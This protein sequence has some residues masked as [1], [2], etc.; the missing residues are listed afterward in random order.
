MKHAAKPLH[1]VP[2]ILAGNA[3][4]ARKLMKSVECCA[5][6]AQIDVMDGTFVPNKTITPAAL[7]HLKTPLK[8]EYHLMV[9]KPLPFVDKAWKSGAWSAIFHLEACKRP[10]DVRTVIRHIKRRKMKAGLAINPE[11]PANA[12][13]PYLHLLDIVLVMT[14]HPGAAG[15]SFV[16]HTLDKIRQIRKWNKKIDIEVDGGI[17]QYTVPKAVKAGANRLVVGSALYTARDGPVLMLSKLKH[18]AE[19]HR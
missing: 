10:L 14:V 5:A 17:N 3:R 4:A 2:A 6:Y 13:K 16:T 1:I 8:L 11:T 19:K 9:A 15:Q 12:V 18:L 7:K